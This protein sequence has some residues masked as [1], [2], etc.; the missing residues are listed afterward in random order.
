MH[1]LDAHPTVMEHIL[2]LRNRAF[3]CVGIFLLGGIV[4]YIFNQ[5]IITALQQP[6][7]GS[8]YYTSPTGSFDIIMRICLM[9]GVVIVVP[10]AFY[11]VMKFIQPA[12][13]KNFSMKKIIGLALIS[14]ALALLGISYA[15][16]ITLPAALHF[17]G[18]FG[19]NSI[20]PMIAADRYFAFVSSYLGIFALVFQLPLILMLASRITPGGPPKLTKYRRYVIVGAFALA[21][22]MPSAPDPLSQA[23]MALPIIVLFELSAMLVWV[24]TRKQRKLL[25]ATAA[26][27]TETVAEAAPVVSVSEPTP[28][29]ELSPEPADMV[30]PRLPR[31][32][33]VVADVVGG[34]PKAPPARVLD[35]RPVQG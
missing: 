8:L 35:L 18:S 10:V 25:A 26:A 11:Q 20:Q 6:L 30:Q 12:I 17:F 27:E 7:H 23:M 29:P 33:M 9:T 32:P 31:A 28:E 19:S 22:L 4:G 34:T 14:L 24:T 1:Q 15:Y 5:P 3:V 16:F 13:G 21:L 2:E